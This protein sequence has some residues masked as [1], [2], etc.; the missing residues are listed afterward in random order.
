MVGTTAGNPMIPTRPLPFY[1]LEFPTPAGR[2]VPYC[3]KDAFIKK[4]ALIIE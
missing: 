4:L 2:A 3:S 1:G